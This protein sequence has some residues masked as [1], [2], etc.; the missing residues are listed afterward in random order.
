MKSR[1][2]TRCPYTLKP[3]AELQ[4]TSREHII[5]DALGGP[6]AYSVTACRLENSNLGATVDA[7]F[8][9]EPVIAM[10]RSKVGI[11]SRSGVAAWKMEGITVKGNRPV[12][13]S[14][15]HQGAVEINH[16][17]PV[18]RDKQN[19][20]YRII[21]PPDQANRILAE[22]RMNLSDKGFTHDIISTSQSPNQTI[23]VSLTCNLNILRAGMM[24]IA[25]LA[26]CH[27]LGNAF[28]DDPLNAEWQKAIRIQNAEQAAASL[29]HCKCF[30]SA[31]HVTKLLLP[32]LQEHE[33]AIAIVNLEQ[34]PVVAVRL[35]GSSML[36]FFARASENN[37]FEISVGDGVIVIC[38]SITRSIGYNSWMEYFLRTADK[39]TL[40]LFKE[41]I[42]E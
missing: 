28:L 32:K 4:T 3:P 8:L 30:E 7:R 22:M 39:S 16:K 21:A 17:K 6:N 23:H 18:E 31:S 15:S 26:C 25:Y 9:S 42:N 11:K 34:G 29:I 27:H 41:T 37:H 2:L 10:F 19:N 1:S 12:G 20:S 5:P 14:F 38:D 36:T 35:F 40:E 13:I 33:H 24:K